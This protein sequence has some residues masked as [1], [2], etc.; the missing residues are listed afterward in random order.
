MVDMMRALVFDGPGRLRL[1]DWPTPEP[2]PGEVV[3][4]V[5]TATICGTDVRIVAGRKTR[6]VR[7]GHPIGHEC[8]G[9]I[10]AVG[11]GVTKFAP[12]DCVAVHPVVTCGECEFCQAD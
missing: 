8:S 11:E 1:R 2:G 9:I 5:H 3:V 7:L 12:G 6:D 4:G 10:A